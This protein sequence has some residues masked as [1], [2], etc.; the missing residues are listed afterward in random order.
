MPLEMDV[1]K[2]NIDVFFGQVLLAFIWMNCMLF[3][4]VKWVAFLNG[5]I[6]VISAYFEV[7]AE[8]EIQG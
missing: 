4:D 5:P 8:L 6:F 7:V 1:D 2:S 3:Q